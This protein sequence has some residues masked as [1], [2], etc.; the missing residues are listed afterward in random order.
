M[1]IVVV[2]IVV[3]QIVVVQIVVVCPPSFFSSLR[4]LCR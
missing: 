1:Q 4:R 2:Q 3:V